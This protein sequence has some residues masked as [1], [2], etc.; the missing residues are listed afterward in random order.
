MIDLPYSLGAMV[1]VDEDG[2]ASIYLNSRLN[3]EKQRACLK[4]ELK[5]LSN[6]DIYN[7]KS[8]REVEE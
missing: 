3:Y 2:F 5:H 1:S 6:D 8:I 4:H 7:D